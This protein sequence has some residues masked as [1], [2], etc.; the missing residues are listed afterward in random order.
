MKEEV[1]RCNDAIAFAF[2]SCSQGRFWT[3]LHSGFSAGDNAPAS[4]SSHCISLIVSELLTW[5]I[6]IV[7]IFRT[8]RCSK[9]VDIGFRSSPSL[10]LA[11]VGRK[12]DNSR[13]TSWPW[14]YSPSATVDDNVPHHSL[15]GLAS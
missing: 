1:L 13:I 8:D 14:P 4:C 2:H 3:K 11:A 7:G 12:P 9:M 6:E 5:L 10:A 15:R